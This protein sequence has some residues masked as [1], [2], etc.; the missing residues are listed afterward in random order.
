MLLQLV[1]VERQRLGKF[2]TVR[3]KTIYSV[4]DLQV[5]FFLTEEA[6]KACS[7]QHKKNHR[8]LR[9]VQNPE[10]QLSCGISSTVYHGRKHTPRGVNT[11]TKHYGHRVCCYS[12]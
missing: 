5:I 11:L 1:E 6:L 2:E 9:A 4:R 7:E 10:L 3:K 12:I 8:S